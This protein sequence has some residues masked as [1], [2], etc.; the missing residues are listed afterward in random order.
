MG[1]GEDEKEE[2]N[3][4]QR[5]DDGVGDR[6]SRFANDDDNTVRVHLASC[7]PRGRGQIC[8]SC[9]ADGRSMALSILSSRGGQIVVGQVVVVGQ[10]FP[11]GGG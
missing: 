9:R 5:E 11:S 7:N 6:C 4:Y 10:T 8:G 3:E 2:E 1:W